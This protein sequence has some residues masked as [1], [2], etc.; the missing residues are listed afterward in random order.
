MYFTID[1]T[2]NIYTWQR[3][4]QALHEQIGDFLLLLT[5]KELS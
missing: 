5:V 2:G 1:P 4:F 3:C